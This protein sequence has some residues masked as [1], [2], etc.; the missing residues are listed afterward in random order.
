MG[1]K[2]CSDGELV[3]LAV[4]ESLI[5][6]FGN[7]SMCKPGSIRF[8]ASGFSLT[9]EVSVSCKVTVTMVG[10]LLFRIN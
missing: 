7:V 1:A 4:S 9:A 3:I 5:S 2:I 8:W 10:T 6:K